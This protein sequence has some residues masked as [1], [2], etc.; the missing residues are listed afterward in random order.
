MGQAQH[1]LQHAHQG[2]ARAALP[3]LIAGLDLHL[4]Q[5]D[6]P[7]AVLVPDELVDG[8][9]EQVEAVIVEVLRHLGL[10]ALQAADDPAVGGGEDDVGAA[11]VAV[12]QAAILP[13]AV[14]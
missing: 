6:V 5:L 12:L 2:A 3:R 11:G 7:V 13:L 9:G 4:G 8:A 1:G 10:G 14:H